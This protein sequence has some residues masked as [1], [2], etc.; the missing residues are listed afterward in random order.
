MQKHYKALVAAT[1]ITLALSACGTAEAPS[2]GASD[3]PFKVGIAIIGQ[4]GPVI[5]TE[6]G[7]KEAFTKAGLVEGKDVV[8]IEKNAQGDQTVIPLMVKQLVQEK[9]D[10][11]LSLGTPVTIALAQET[12]TIPIIFGAMT[13]PVG[14]GVITANDA[15]GGNLT[16]TS[17]LL[18]PTILLNLVKDT[19]PNAKRV[20]IIANPGEQNS[21]VQLKALNESAASYGFE[22][23][24]APVTTTA[25]AIPAA[26]SLRGRVDAVILPQDNTVGEAFESIAK[27]LLDA[28]LPIIAANVDR[29]KDGAALVGLG[30]DYRGLG[31]LTG[32]QAVKVLKGEASPKDTPVIFANSPGGGGLKVAVN[33]AVAS[34]LKIT[35]SESVVKD[36]TVYDSSPLVK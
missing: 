1:A 3:G 20:G 29:V 34:Y 27:T 18:D 5:S 8:F 16:G 21:A 4:I 12:T 2:D 24:T 17:D 25:D 33:T 28:G 10:L 11:I 30:V 32:E 14:A 7:F 15:P 13:D 36:A 19:V 35:I 31:L 9:P 6:E 23:I 26:M 22:L